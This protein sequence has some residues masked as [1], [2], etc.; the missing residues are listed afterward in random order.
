MKPGSTWRHKYSKELCVIER[1]VK[2][3]SAIEGKW[4]TGVLYKMGDEYQVRIKDD[5]LAKFSEDKNGK[6][7]ISGS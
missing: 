5:F 2:I 7:E 3:S 1:E 4:F 6:S